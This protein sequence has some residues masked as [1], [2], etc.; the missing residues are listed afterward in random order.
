M[1]E[2]TRAVEFDVSAATIAVAVAAPGRTPAVE[3]GVLA[4]D[5]AAMRHWVAP[6]AGP[7]HAAGVLRGGANG[8]WATAAAGGHGGRVSSHRARAGA[9]A[10]DGPHQ[11]RPARCAPPGGR[12]A[13]GVADAGVV[14][15]AG[16]AAGEG[17]SAALG[18][19][20]ARGIHGVGAGGEG[21]SWRT[22]QRLHAR[23][24]TQR[25]RRSTPKA[26]AAVA[27]ELRRYLGNWRR[28]CAS[29]PRGRCPPPPESLTVSGRGAVSPEQDRGAWSR[30]PS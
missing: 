7:G 13:G 22:Q 15:P 3:A 19:A 25:G 21:M 17:H 23:L 16:A 9:H 2:Y 6:T 20:A 27:Q 1:S 14:P 12:E 10:A 11:D 8:V 28:G 30:E 18:A 26:I 5:A 24:R 29:S 4:A